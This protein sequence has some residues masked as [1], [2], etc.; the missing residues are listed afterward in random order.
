MS[1]DDKK[2]YVDLHEKVRNT[3][4]YCHVYNI[5]HDLIKGR[6]FGIITDYVLYEISCKYFN[7]RNI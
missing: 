6:L 3:Y 4:L 1:Y 5:K 7:L 2:D